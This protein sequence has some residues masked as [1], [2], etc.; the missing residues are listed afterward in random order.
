MVTLGNDK[1][2]DYIGK[3]LDEQE[4]RDPNK[5][6]RIHILKYRWIER[7]WTV[8]YGPLTLQTILPR[9]WKEWHQVRDVAKVDGPDEAIDNRKQSAYRTYILHFHKSN[10]LKRHQINKNMPLY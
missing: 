7:N 2:C 5:S 9:N 10:V 4:I 6:Q 8:V 3:D 1:V